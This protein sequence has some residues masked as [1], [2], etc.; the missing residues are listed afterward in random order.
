MDPDATLEELRKLA[1]HVTS[2]VDSVDID[3]YTDRAVLHDLTEDA[4]NL[5]TL[6]HSLDEWIGKGG[7]LP[8]E[9]QPSTDDDDDVLRNEVAGLP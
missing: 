9:W 6:F 4:E 1:T 2:T 5:A 8:T 3:T 7:F